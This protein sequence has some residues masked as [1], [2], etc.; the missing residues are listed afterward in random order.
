[1]DEK[2]RHLAQMGKERMR[3]GCRWESQKER[4]NW[5]DQDV[6]EW[7]II[8][9]ILERKDGV[10]WTGLVRQGYGPVEG[11]CEHSDKPSVSLKS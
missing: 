3:T 8:R 5:E 2:G 10:V 11:S 6:R 7:I 4:D 9:W 1:V